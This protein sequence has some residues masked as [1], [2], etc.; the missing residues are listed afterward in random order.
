[1]GIDDPKQKIIYGDDFSFTCYATELQ[2]NSREVKYSA[3]NIYPHF[4]DGIPYLLIEESVVNPHFVKQAMNRVYGF[5]GVNP[6]KRE[7]MFN[8]TTL[9][10]KKS[11]WFKRTSAY[12][13]ELSLADLER[14][15]LLGQAADGLK[16][17]T[18]GL[19]TK[20]EAIFSEIDKKHEYK[21]NEYADN[22]VL[23]MLPGR[24]EFKFFALIVLGAGLLAWLA[25]FILKAF[26]KN[27]LEKKSFAQAD[28]EDLMDWGFLKQ[29]ATEILRVRRHN[30][31]LLKDYNTIKQELEDSLAKTIS[32]MK[33]K[34]KQRH[35][36]RQKQALSK[37]GKSFQIAYK[38]QDKRITSF[39]GEI[40]TFEDLLKEYNLDDN[41]S[42]DPTAPGIKDIVEQSGL[43]LSDTKAVFDRIIFSRN[44]L[45]EETFRVRLLAELMR[46]ACFYRGTKV[47]SGKVMQ[48]D[49]LMKKEVVERLSLEVRRLFKNL[50]LGISPDEDNFTGEHAYLF[51]TVMEAIK[52]PA[53]FEELDLP[54]RKSAIGV[55]IVAND[56]LEKEANR[57][58]GIRNRL[59]PLEQFVLRQVTLLKAI[60]MNGNGRFEEWIY[61]KITSDSRTSGWYND[62]VQA[63]LALKFINNIY[64][65][66]AGG[67]LLNQMHIKAE[68]VKDR[69]G[70]YRYHQWSLL[71]EEMND[72]FRYLLGQDDWEPD[73]KLKDT[74]VNVEKLRIKV[75]SYLDRITM[76]EEKIDA[77]EFLRYIKAVIMSVENTMQRPRVKH[78]LEFYQLFWMPFWKFVISRSLRRKVLAKDNPFKQHLSDWNRKFNVKAVFMGVAGFM[79]Y[80][81]YNAIL[82]S[83]LVGVPFFITFPQFIFLIPVALLV[84]QGVYLALRHKAIKEANPDG[85]LRKHI[86][87]LGLQALMLAL[88][89]GFVLF[90]PLAGNVTM[91]L[92]EIVRMILKGVLFMIV[93]E[94]FRLTFYSVHYAVKAVV[95]YKHYKKNEVYSVVKPAELPEALD[96]IFSD[97]GKGWYFKTQ[98]TTMGQERIEIF[99]RAILDE[100]SNQDDCQLLIGQ[101]DLKVWEELLK[102]YESSQRDMPKLKGL[103]LKGDADAVKERVHRI[104]RWV[105]D[106]LR[107]DKPSPPRTIRDT[108]AYN[109]SK[110]GYEEESYLSLDKIN[111]PENPNIEQ[112]TR[113]GMLARDK[114]AYWKALI[115]RLKEGMIVGGEKVCL[116]D[117]D[118]EK[119]EALAEDPLQKLFINPKLMPYIVRWANTHLPTLW[120][121]S[122]SSLKVKRRFLYT[123]AQILP[124][125]LPDKDK[126]V[127]L[128][129][130]DKA[131]R[132]MMKHSGSMNYIE[133]TF[134][135]LSDA[136]RGGVKINTFREYLYYYL[137]HRRQQ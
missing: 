6:N 22:G 110:Q 24:S 27:R 125:D 115:A 73:G 72:A 64:A 65:P 83:G 114:P 11:P 44:Q 10:I 129:A 84:V 37:L 107:K 111:D 52:Q 53:D 119:M 92:P 25:H 34:N 88:G 63:K 117:S 97:T 36:R 106:Q 3:F 136:E 122:V 16:T 41:A 131:K 137:P 43:S 61:Q 57:D 133:E 15:S 89:F 76:G 17:N 38:V 94:T 19:K 9:L 130:E 103:L 48:I 33:E 28:I 14:N 8:G 91:V 1:M 126:W 123:I 68:S 20:R 39:T 108:L 46:E 113:L 30:P 51:D 96:R 54:R 62:S 100:F 2:D 85:A 78:R 69:F 49:T 29:E 82:N 45:S 105:N 70:I 95:V 120:S 102:K 87:Q 18:L 55:Y 99:R 26:F 59:V 74:G 86:R 109:L 58:L 90:A 35:I 98:N 118:E 12:P 47:E 23:K 132:N 127:A 104:I 121:T 112:V 60:A 116:S 42:A 32:G 79:S 50:G 93:F 31:D 81:F 4:E 56:D 71:W 7:L 75:N 13:S 5:F 77:E 124:K 128:L 101:D 21:R 134:K 40:A 67:L 80:L 66:L 135:T